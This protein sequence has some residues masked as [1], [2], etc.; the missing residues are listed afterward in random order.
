MTAYMAPG[1]QTV[2]E[3][4]ASQWLTTVEEMHTKKRN[5]D[6]AEAR[7]VV[8]WY[9]HERRGYSFFMAGKIFGKN[10]A[11]AIHARNTVNNLIETDRNF[12]GRLE[13]V[14]RHIEKI[15][16]KLGFELK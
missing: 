11:T 7:Q 10:H 5:G 1:Y 4:V 15:N 13:T 14:L 8:M 9:A 12:R 6:V 2:E 16:A 3:I